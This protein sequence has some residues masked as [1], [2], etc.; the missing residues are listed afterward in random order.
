MFPILYDNSGNKL[1]DFESFG[2]GVLTDCSECIVTEERN[3]DYACDFTYPVSGRLF[4]DIYVGN[5]IKSK[6]HNGSNQLFRI[7]KISKRMDGICRY[8]CEHI[9]RD[10]ANDMIQEYTHS[11]PITPAEALTYILEHSKYNGTLSEFEGFTGITSGFVNVSAPM[12]L[13]KPTTTMKALVGEEGSLVDVF[14]GEYEFD[15]FEVKYKL[16]RGID[17]NVKITYGKNLTDITFD[18]DLSKLYNYAVPYISTSDG[19]YINAGV[20]EVAP[21][22]ETGIIGIIRY[23]PLDLSGYFDEAQLSTLSPEQ[24]RERAEKV[25]KENNIGKINYNISVSFAALQNTKDYEQIAQFETINLCDTVTVEHPVLDVNSKAKV[26]KIQ[27]DALKEKIISME[28][29]NLKNNL[30]QSI[31]K[32]I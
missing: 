32:N 2:L 3:R 30:L 6:T 11:G 14:G 4:S 24:V 1:S 17:R 13:K 31:A 18:F 21:E 26:V 20:T 19:G 7:K 9:S 8:Y 5:I 10:L 28:L 12:R 29:G 15:N 23:M 22:G 16:K 27:Y 25:L